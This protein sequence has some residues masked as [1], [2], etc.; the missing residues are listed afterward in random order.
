MFLQ[1]LIDAFSLATRNLAMGSAILIPEI[2]IALVF[3]AV[4]WVLAALLEKLVESVFK[5]VRVD[6]ALKSAGLEEV[7]KRAGYNLNSGLFVGVIV[8]WFVILAFLT[9]SFSALQLTQVN[10][11]LLGILS[12]LP[13]VIVAVL[14]LMAAIVVASAMQKI[15]VASARAAHMKSAEL[16]GKTTKWA[17][18]IFGLLVTLSNLQIE[19][20]IVFVLV[21]LLFAG[22]ALALGLAFGLGG[23]DVAARLIE[24]TAHTILEKE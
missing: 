10:E 15:V 14:I 4:G 5:A 13:H 9:A 6:A 3:L 20:S 1:S 24:K 21:Q 23:K 17:I 11:F 22:I 16:L 7:V 19:M 8:K 18:F 2:I 12:Y